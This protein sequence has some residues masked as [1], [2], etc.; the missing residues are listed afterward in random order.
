MSCPSGT[1]L[2]QGK[3]YNTT[4]AYAPNDLSTA[5]SARPQKTEC[6]YISINYTMLGHFSASENPDFFL[7]IPSSLTSLD[8]A[9][10]TCTPALYGAW[11][12]PKTLPTATVLTDPA[13][14][15]TPSRPTTTTGRSTPVFAPA[16]TTAVVDSPVNATPSIASVPR[17]PRTSSVPKTSAAELTDPAINQDSHSTAALER[18]SNTIPSMPSGEAG[19]PDI[20]NASKVSSASEP[21]STGAESLVQG[22]SGSAEIET[23]SYRPGSVAHMSEQGMSIS[24]SAVIMSGSNF[25]LPSP[26]APTPTLPFIYS[27]PM[28]SAPDGGLVFASSTITL[29]LQATISGHTITLDLSDAVIDGS[30]YAHPMR[31]PENTQLSPLTLGNG[32][33]ASLDSD[34]NKLKIGSQIISVNG[35]AINISGTT[36]SPG[37]SGLY[38]GSSVLPLTATI[39]NSS[40][41]LGKL[42]TSPFQSEPSPTGNSGN[43]SNAVIST[44]GLPSSP[45]CYSIS[46]LAFMMAIIAM[47]ALVL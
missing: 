46:V 30:K 20:S 23:E 2:A 1:T 17:F 40:A 47:I 39:D 26:L 12:P 27:K 41:G 43:G 11:D 3:S 24:S 42:I 15:I 5:M 18:P 22:P 8:P 14:R 38:I 4:V 10:T 29:G 21:P 33:V 7:S 28:T 16:T 19:K 13:K 9:W 44:G 36:V 37:A 35:P 25:I 31:P 34:P 6:T 45:N 32:T